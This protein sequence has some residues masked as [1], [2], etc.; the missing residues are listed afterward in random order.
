MAMEKIKPKNHFGIFGRITSKH[1]SKLGLK[2]I[3]ILSLISL[4]SCGSS[5]RA[6]IAKNQR[7]STVQNVVEYSKKYL[8][9]PYKYGGNT[10]SGMDCSGLIQLSFM[11]YGIQLPRVSRAMSKTGK[12]IPLKHVEI[13]DLVFFRTSKNSRRINHVGLVV[14]RNKANVEFIHSSSSKGVM[15]SSILNPY[16]RRN[17]VKS[18]RVV[19]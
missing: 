6:K 8:G 11:Q 2:I 10:S 13:G 4:V 1:W 3:L 14:K 7:T 16:W 9:T 18:R 12:P 19:F 15:I 5:K 17:Y